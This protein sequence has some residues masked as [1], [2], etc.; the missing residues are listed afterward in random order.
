M[1]RRTANF[2]IYLHDYVVLFCLDGVHT[3]IEYDGY[4]LEVVQ[5]DEIDSCHGF[6]GWFIAIVIKCKHLHTPQDDRIHTCTG[7]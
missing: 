1:N 7:R 4:T 2:A 3:D 5:H 6:I